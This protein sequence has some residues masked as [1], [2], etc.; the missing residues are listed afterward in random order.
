MPISV[1]IWG[2]SLEEK[3]VFPTS[4]FLWAC[5]GKGKQFLLQPEWDT[6]GTSEQGPPWAQH[7]VTKAGEREDVIRGKT[8]AGD[9]FKKRMSN[10]RSV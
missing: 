1:F 5:V 7:K 3:K 9:K 8:Q 2:F 4:L 6:R 10:Q